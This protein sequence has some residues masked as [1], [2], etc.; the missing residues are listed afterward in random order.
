[1]KIILWLLF[2]SL[3]LWL[4]FVLSKKIDR[5]VLIKGFILL[6]PAVIV[7]WLLIALSCRVLGF[8]P[9][10]GFFDIFMAAFMSFMII[11]MINI[12][13]QL[14]YYMLDAVN[15]FHQK[16]NAGNLNRQPIKFFID[17]QTMLKRAA[18]IIWFL[19]SALMLYG[20]WLGKK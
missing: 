13:N 8:I 2:V 10:A 5:P 1:M 15:S 7:I 4:L 3:N 12:F 18:S 17:N 20:V 9:A 14:F 6:M 16:N 11:A 19:G